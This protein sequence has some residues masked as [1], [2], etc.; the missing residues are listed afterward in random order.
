MTE[1]MISLEPVQRISD[2]EDALVFMSS[3]RRLLC[4]G[5]VSWGVAYFF[6]NVRGEGL[7]VWLWWLVVISGRIVEYVGVPVARFYASEVKA[8]ALPR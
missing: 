2:S 5:S 1:G 7:L 4:I 3:G 8:V 6:G